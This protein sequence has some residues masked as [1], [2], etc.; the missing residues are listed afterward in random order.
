MKKEEYLYI[1]L[2]QLIYD[3]SCTNDGCLTKNEMKTIAKNPL[4]SF[5]KEY[6]YLFFKH[7]LDAKTHTLDAYNK[8]LENIYKGSDYLTMAMI[9]EILDV[10]NQVQGKMQQKHKDTTELYK[11]RLKEDLKECLSLD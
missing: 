9:Y 8:A 10:C 7:L 6:K 3:F 5:N 1:G 2:A 11:I 4:K